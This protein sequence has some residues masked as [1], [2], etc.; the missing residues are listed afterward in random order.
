MQI[1]RQRQLPGADFTNPRLVALPST[2]RH[3]ATALRMMAD[4]AGRGVADAPLIRSRA[5]PAGPEGAEWPSV[6]DV[7]TWLLELSEAGWLRLYRD[8]A[9]TGA[10]LFQ[11]I[12]R[13]PKVQKE[14]EAQYS[15]P[16]ADPDPPAENGEIPPFLTAAVGGEGAGASEREGESVG[17]SVRASAG[18]SAGA[19]VGLSRSTSKPRLPPPPFCSKHPGGP[20]EGLDCRDCG[21]ARLRNQQHKDLRAARAE[22]E[23]LDPLLRVPMLAHLDA[24]LLAL[25]EAAAGALLGPR[26]VVSVPVEFVD[27]HGRID[28]T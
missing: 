17:V 11:I 7:E 25:E 13:W 15:A 10:E 28:H 5:W 12:A 1:N 16:P 6:D 23:H 8:P 21:T 4:P 22:A 20:P 2:C 24:Q 9:G 18:V 27:E 3:L 14:G 26:P 19:G